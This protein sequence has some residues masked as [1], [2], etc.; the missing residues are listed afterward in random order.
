[1]TPITIDFETYWTT[2]FSLSKI[3]FIEYI[4]SPEFEVISVSVKIGSAAT[5][6]YFGDD[7]GPALRSID[8]SD[9]ACVGHNGNEFDFPLLVWTYDVHPAL[10]VDTLALSKARHQSYVGGSLKKLSAHYNLPVKDNTVLL[11]TKGRRLSEF[12]AREVDEMGTYNKTDT[13]NTSELFKLLRAPDIEGM[14]DLR[15][16]AAVAQ[17]MKRELL[18]S[19][20]TARLICY[21]QLHCDTALLD[22]TLVQA[23]TI[24]QQQLEALTDVLNVLDVEE[25]RATL[26][27]APRFAEALRSFGVEPPT[28]I[29]KTTGK[30]ALALA[31]TD[32]EFTALLEHEDERVQLITSTRLGVKSTLLETRL[33]R[34]SVCA[35]MMGGRMP[36]PLAYHAATTG[37]W[38]GRVWNPQNLPRIGR[39]K[40]GSIVPKLSNALRQ[41]LVAPPGHL[42]V[43]SDL[44]GIELR[45]NHYLWD[46]PSTRALY[47]GDAEADLYKYFAASLY[48][49]PEASISKDQ[50]Q[51]GKLCLAE[52]TLIL[53]RKQY[54]VEW[55]P[56]ERFTADRQLWDGEE[57][58]WAKGVVSNGWRP[59]QSLCGLW[60]TPDHL[61]LSGT[62]WLQAKDVRG[63]RISLAL[64]TA[65]ENLSLW[66][67]LPSIATGSLRLSSSAIVGFLS[68]RWR[69]TISKTSRRLGAMLVPRKPRGP[70]DTGST[71]WK[72]LTMFPAQ[73]YWTGFPQ[74]S[75]D[76]TNPRTQ[77]TPT[78][79]AGASQYA[80]SGG[81]TAL[82]F[83]RIFGGL[84]AGKT[85]LMKWTELTATKGTSRA[86]SDSSADETTCSTNAKYQKCSDAST[87]SKRS[88]PVYDILDCGLRNR[89]T[90]LTAKGPIIVHNCHLGLGF[91]AGAAT[92][93]KVAK[94]MGGIDLDPDEALRVTTTWRV[95]YHEIVDG[96]RA[97]QRLIA[98]MYQG[99]AFSPD[100]RQLVH[101][102]QRKVRLPSGRFL[103]YPELRSTIDDR[104]KQQYRYGSGRT[105]S[106]VYSGLMDENLV[107]AIARD[108]IAEQALTIRQHTG[109]TPALLV[110]DELVY[111]VPEAQAEQHLADINHIMRQP[112]RWLPGIVLWS[113]GD[114]AANYGSA[115]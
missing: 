100:P 30:E 16:I 94:L 9:K 109:Y 66:E 44:S 28:K 12:S 2:D 42:I 29:S 41:S 46:V 18:I 14:E 114:I 3:S 77:V 101:A 64:A 103:Y 87:N 74:P 95:K 15:D 63:E 89:F 53:T 57:W 54:S 113:E 24:K 91:G 69:A 60:L 10:F 5:E 17:A 25:V 8:W 105:E 102:G 90:A 59:T 43:V 33:H 111:V 79:G 71:W 39:N 13:E 85:L 20:M 26:A 65:A 93:Q 19:D 22:E 97:C 68:T 56:I 40:D 38:G 81:S 51:M 11:N 7:V 107:Q 50:R 86:T 108:V 98:A 106:K 35:K 1:M 48:G 110:H 62:Q 55:I 4:Q 61:V 70:S 92:F 99:A 49:V 72:C 76:A 27:S 34:M 37:R 96:W 21:P 67:L 6:V 73:G 52:G 83:S 115:K 82:L 36:V 58:V 75:T 112:P 84:T 78:T 45:V 104:G 88:L 32:E 80:T 31:K 47:A 23:E